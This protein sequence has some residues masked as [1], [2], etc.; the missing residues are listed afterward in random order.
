MKFKLKSAAVEID[1]NTLTVRQLTHG[2]RF[3]FSKVA[4]DAKESG[5]RAATPVF[6]LTTCALEP[7]LTPEDIS[8]MPSDLADA[9]LNKIMEL[10]GMADDDSEKKG[11]RP[12][13]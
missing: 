6:L 9:A 11:S 1:G 3:E 8:D 13:S 5:D 12:A 2:E 10:S 7:K 4:R